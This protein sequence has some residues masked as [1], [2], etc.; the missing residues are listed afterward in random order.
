MTKSVA[1]SSTQLRSRAHLCSRDQEYYFVNIVF[2]VEDNIFN[3]PR[4]HFERSSEIFAGMLA[5][6][7]GDSVNVEGRTDE[8][9]VV[10]E[11]ISSADFRALLKALYPLDII[12][13]NWT[14]MTN[15]EWISVLKL[16]TQ[17]RFLDARNLAI[18]QL[19]RR[20]D[21]QIV[22]RILLARQYDVVAWLRKGY[23]D[24]ARR[25]QCISQEEAKKIGWETA[26]RICEAREAAITR[27][28]DDYSYFLGYTDIEDKFRE[29]F[30]EAEF[31][32]AVFDLPQ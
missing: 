2:Q 7:A 13:T 19:Q 25:K 16:S 28:C 30:K 14:T 9:P 6:P 24:L 4:Y 26:F 10:L 8:N 20:A 29:E 3:V 15:D 17:W 27:K 22:E 31:A 12:R 1:P 18:E 32:S 5:L 11:G 21:L 23:I